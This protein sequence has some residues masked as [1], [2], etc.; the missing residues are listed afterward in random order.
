MFAAR[1]HDLP[2]LL[3]GKLHALITRAYPKGRDWYDLIWYRAV[4]PP[5]EPNLV[6]LQNALRGFI[7]RRR[8][9][10]GPELLPRLL[11]DTIGRQDCLAQG[12]RWP[13]DAAAIG[14]LPR[15]LAMPPSWS[16]ASTLGVAL[17]LFVVTM[18]SQNVPGV[19]VLRASGYAGAP[20]SRLV[21]ITGLATLLLAPFGAFALNLAAITAALCMGEAAHPDPARRWLAAAA[22]G[23]FYLLIAAFAAP[24]A[25][26]FTA[27]PRELVV[28]VAGLALLP[29]I[30]RGLHTA[31][32]SDAQREPALVTF[33]VTASGLTLGGI[34]SAFWGI[35][36][37]AIAL[38][39][40]REPTRH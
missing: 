23:A 33:L 39:V 36:F 35:V 25:A 14:V 31:L 2:S 3:A 26:L 30:A 22:A 12:L 13:A 40:W 28:T 29:T 17:P 1:H 18:A 21:A 8:D 20:I 9:V 10:D 24:I 37:G 19:A 7:G 15:P 27:L 6:L 32:A 5:I 11:G 38:L 4:R 34:G 16:V